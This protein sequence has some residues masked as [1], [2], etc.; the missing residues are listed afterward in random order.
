M[1]CTI[2]RVGVSTANGGDG[3]SLADPF[4]WQVSGRQVQI[5][6]RHVASSDAA[7]TWFAEQIQGLDPSLNLDE[8]SIPFTSSAVPTLDGYYSVEGAQATIGRGALGTGTL[9]VDWQVSMRRAVDSTKPRLEIPHTWAFLTNTLSVTQANLFLGTPGGATNIRQSFTPNVGN[10]LVMRASE[11]GT[12]E[13]LYNNNAASSSTGYSVAQYVVTPQSFYKGGCRI[14]NGSGSVVGRRDLTLPTGSDTVTVSN[15]LVRLQ[16]TSGTTFTVSYYLAGWVSLLTFPIAEGFAA[17]PDATPKA[18]SVLKNGSDE[19]VLRF[20]L[21]RTDTSY[22]GAVRS[23]TVDVSVRR[24]SMMVHL[25]C[26]VNSTVTGI[27]LR[28]ST[29]VAGTSIN[30]GIRS[31]SADVNGVYKL[32]TSNNVATRDT[33]NLGLYSDPLFTQKALFGVGWAEGVGSNTTGTGG[34]NFNYTT[35]I[36]QEFFFANATTQ[37]VVVG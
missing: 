5:A 35:D 23:V 2:G 16:Y 7:A 30:G 22:T 4:E 24:G 28:S 32:V 31:T 33:T 10:A 20:V 26:V 15:G 12:V 29:A 21:I 9:H 19:V 1:T 17:Y 27:S 3:L 13:G 18:V 8:P 34:K 14:S 25:G 6:G 36:S 37:R 11:T